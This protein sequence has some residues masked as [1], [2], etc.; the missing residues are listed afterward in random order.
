MLA[1]SRHDSKRFRGGHLPTVTLLH[2]CFSRDIDSAY[3]DPIPRLSWSAAG[4]IARGRI[5]RWAYSKLLSALFGLIVLNSSNAMSGTFNAA[6]ARPLFAPS[7]RPPTVIEATAPPSPGPPPPPSLAL[8]G[9]ILGPG[10]AVALLIRQG[11]A[12]AKGVAL[13]G[14]ID[15]WHV[16]EIRPREVLLTHDN[17]TVTLMIHEGVR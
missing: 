17:Q 9:I 2:H 7:R 4:I 3:R 1:T 16:S 6:R 12:E 8:S 10:V 5:V 13:G 15:G 11:S 14:S